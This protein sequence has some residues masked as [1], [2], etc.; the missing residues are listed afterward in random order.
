MNTH[1]NPNEATSSDKTDTP[2]R[3]TDRCRPGKR[4][5]VER[6]P[7]LPAVTHPAVALARYPTAEWHPIDAE[8]CVCRSRR[9]QAVRPG[10]RINRTL[11]CCRGCTTVKGATCTA[12]QPSCRAVFD[13]IRVAAPA[14]VQDAIDLMELTSRAADLFAVQPVHEKQ[15]F[16]RLIMKSATW[17]KGQLQTEFEQPFENM[18]RSN[19]PSQTKHI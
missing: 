1:T 8:C 16:L 14:A 11:P 17:R 2:P 18:R 10:P 9:E 6:I 15:G 12:S 5:R 3:S 4:A 19:Q 7:D 13:E